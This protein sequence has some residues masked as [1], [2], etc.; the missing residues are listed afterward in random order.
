M[1]NQRSHQWNPALGSDCSGLYA[2]TWICVGVRSS[3]PALTLSWETSTAD[4]T[5]PPAPTSY[6]PPT[7]PAVDSS[8]VPSPSEGPMPTNCAN[9]YQVETDQNCNDVL[10][11]YNYITKEQFFAWNPVLKGDCLGLW[12]GNWYCVGV[13]DNGLPPAPAVATAAPSTLPPGSPSDCTR[14]YETTGEDSC[15]DIVGMFGSFS[16]SDF[17]SWNPSVFDDCSGI[18][19]GVWYCVGKSNTPTTRT[20]KST[21]TLPT[22]IPTQSGITASCKQ[23]WLVSDDD[24]CHDIAYVNGLSDEDFIHMNPAL[25]DNCEGLTADYYVCVSSNTTTTATTIGATSPAVSSTSIATT[26]TKP[27]TS[28]TAAAGGVTTP[29]PVRDGM[30][31]SCKKF[32]L[33]QSG[34]LCWQMAQD[35][36]IT[37]EYVSSIS[38]F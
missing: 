20:D 13:N 19:D 34:E 29:S 17:L 23:Y 21:P 2:D 4:F 11:I 16:L 14:W 12:V 32:H 5:S 33:M 3:A 28:T 36:N 9:Y 31:T 10:A 24:T 15:D 7:L 30:T 35:A 1:F 25:G 26:T 38:V 6:T 27:T 37:V 22:S 18:A 8:F